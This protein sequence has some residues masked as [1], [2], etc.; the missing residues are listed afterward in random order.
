MIDK[1]KQSSTPRI[2]DRG[3]GPEIEGTR[4]TVYRIMDFL[5]ERS[6]PAAVAAELNLSAAQVEAALQ[7]IAAHRDDVEAE[8]E[9]IVARNTRGNPEWVQRG[10]AK[11]AR[12]LQERILS[13][14]AGATHAH[15]RG[16]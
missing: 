15:P 13:R 10:A 5:R 6:A 7:Y 4:V 16:Q 3:R 9:R 12:E 14:H 1:S 2:I 11:S 8:Y